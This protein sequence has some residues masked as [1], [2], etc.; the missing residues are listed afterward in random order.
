MVN[1]FGSFLAKVSVVER[2]ALSTYSLSTDTYVAGGV[3]RRIAKV[4]G[5]MFVS[6]RVFLTFEVNLENLRHSL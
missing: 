3:G 6:V 2:N 4:I 5:E 1:Y